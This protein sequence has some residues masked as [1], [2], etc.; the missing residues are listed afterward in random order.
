MRITT[1]L[2]FALWFVSFLANSQDEA[3]KEKY[4]AELKNASNA[5]SSYFYPNY[6][7]IYAQTEKAAVAKIDSIRN[8]F[9]AILNKYKAE[10]QPE[11]V[12]DQKLE[13]N[14]FFDKLLLDYPNSH[15]TY[16]PGEK[17]TRLSKALSARLEKNVS[18]FN[19]PELLTN[20]DFTAYVKAYFHHAVRQ[21]LVSPA[22]KNTDNQVLTATWKLIPRVITHP[23]CKEFWQTEYLFN[24][25]DNNGIKNIQPFLVEFKA[26]Y[27]NSDS[28]KKIH[29]IYAED[30]AGRQ[31][32]LVQVYKTASGVPLDLHLFPPDGSVFPGKH[33]VFVYFHG[34][35]WSEGKPDWGF[36]SCEAYAK[37]GWIGVAVEYRT[38]GR[39][40]TLPFESVMDARSAIRWL[41]KN[42][43]QFNI[44]TARIVATGNSAGGHL[45]LT[46]ALADKWNEATDDLHVSPKPN[47]LLVNSGVYDLTTDNTK[48]ITRNIKN[49]EVVKQ[50]SPN[51]LPKQN[52]PPLLVVHGTNDSNCPYWTAEKFR[53]EAVKVNGNFEF[54]ALEGASHFLWYDQKFT[55][56]ISAWRKDFLAKWGFE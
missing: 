36:G 21:E 5:F 18:D 14:Y 25:I 50:I 32:H 23:A 13:I 7:T 43:S 31:N 33:P 1:V 35:S 34:G 4:K 45:V 41:R 6:V 49:K 56:Q 8:A 39:N 10:L 20:A 51:H 9:H 47:V 24:H 54:H 46:T 2:T 48:W 16:A 12:A 3:T 29:A 37:K 22:Y 53:E 52:M 28:W 26:S 19:K 40:N 17:E 15:D 55:R 42:A 44:D 38:A 30:S 11:F 27:P